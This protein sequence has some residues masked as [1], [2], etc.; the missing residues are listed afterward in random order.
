MAALAGKGSALLA[1]MTH[2]LQRVFA[3]HRV[4]CLTEIFAT[5]LP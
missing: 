1:S 3:A 2:L 5:L 4:V